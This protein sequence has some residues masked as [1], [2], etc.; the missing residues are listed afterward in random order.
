MKILLR[1]DIGST[2]YKRNQSMTIDTVKY[3]MYL[4]D[5]VPYQEYYNEKSDGLL[6][7]NFNTNSKEIRQ[8]ESLLFCRNLAF[9]SYREKLLVDIG[10]VIMTERVKIDL[11]LAH[12]LGST[13]YYYGRGYRLRE[14]TVK[15]I[16]VST[17][18]I[19]TNVKYLL[20]SKN[21]GNER[22]YPGINT[23]S[24][25]DVHTQYVHADEIF[26]SRVDYLEYKLAD[27]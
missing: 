2:V 27:S 7:F 3:I 21:T 24:Y 6:Y 17:N 5:S 12:E 23:T 25:S 26:K 13:V 10:E 14:S 16:V 11:P 20:E 18:S 22:N 9:N 4:G 15:G 8:G 1:H 19:E